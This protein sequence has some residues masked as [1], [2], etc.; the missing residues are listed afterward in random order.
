VAEHAFT[1]GLLHDVGK[2]VLAVH[3][4][5]LYKQTLTLIQT[6]NITDWQAEQTVF[7]ATHAEVGAYLLGLWGLPDGI[8]EALAYHHNPR[9]QCGH[10]AFTPLTAVHIAHALTHRMDAVDAGSQAEL[11]DLDYLA[12]IGLG[13]RLAVWQERYQIVH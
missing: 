8:V 6:E 10:L 11:V 3:Y 7:N 2:L 1:A 13:D 12:Q 5:E 9:R 4:P